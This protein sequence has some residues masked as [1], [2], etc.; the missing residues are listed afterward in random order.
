MDRRRKSQIG[1]PGVF[2]LFLTA[3]G[4]ADPGEGK[5]EC[6]SEHQ[7]EIHVKTGDYGAK[8]DYSVPRKQVL[9]EIGTATW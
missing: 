9:L 1:L 4:M 7:P 8:G 5:L 2:L 3:A 6:F